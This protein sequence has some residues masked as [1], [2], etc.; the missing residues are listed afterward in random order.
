M[1]L[2]RTIA[3]FSFGLLAAAC[4]SDQTL[5]PSTDNILRTYIG[6]TPAA[7][8]TYS[9]LTPVS[10]LQTDAGMVFQFAG[11]GPTAI[12]SPSTPSFQNITDPGIAAGFRSIGAAM[13]G[14][15]FAV[16]ARCQVQLVTE[17]INCRGNMDSFRVV[18][19]VYDGAC[20][21]VQPNAA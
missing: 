13:T 8:A 4:V 18:E 19:I 16:Q 12:Y 2:A 11:I 20:G 15:A 6:D 3:P 7:F 14:P 9:G 10:S 17:R 21:M 1:P 5:G